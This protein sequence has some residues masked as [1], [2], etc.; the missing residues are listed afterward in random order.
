MLRRLFG[1][2]SSRL[3]TPR[4]HKRFRRPPRLS[5]GWRLALVCLALAAAAEVFLHRRQYAVRQPDIELDEPFYTTCQEP[6]VDAPRENAALVMLAR[7]KE[8]AKALKT[9][10]SIERHFNRWFHYP[11]V[12]M[13]D[14]PW[15][16]EFI[17]AMNA[18][19]S[20]EVRF[21]VIPRDEWTFPEWMDVD[22][23]KESIAAQGRAGILYAGMETYHHM[24]RFYSGYVFLRNPV[25][26]LDAD[27]LVTSQELL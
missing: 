22:A 11:I 18:T 20:G 7:N 3:G 8:L 1:G 16:E 23:T 17:N 15:S 19:A 26:R 13:N 6:K 21:E 27:V 24:C 4:Y 5:R 12:F 14:E 9:V 25:Y 2:S 10:Q